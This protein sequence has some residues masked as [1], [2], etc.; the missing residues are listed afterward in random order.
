VAVSH[1]ALGGA[2]RARDGIARPWR[3]LWIDL[4]WAHL[5]GLEALEEWRGSQG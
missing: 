2:E 4:R 3:K 1:A 5:A